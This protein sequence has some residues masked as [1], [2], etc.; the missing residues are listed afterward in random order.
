MFIE[1]PRAYVVA[2]SAAGRDQDP[3]WYLNLQSSPEVG[4]RIGKRSISV[5]ARFAEENDRERL[6]TSFSETAK[7]YADYQQKTER[8]IPVVILEPQG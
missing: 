6:F 4:V 1:E 8:Q 2:G 5:R 7:R 3:A